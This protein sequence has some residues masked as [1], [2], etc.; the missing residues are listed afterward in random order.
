MPDPSS[1][2]SPSSLSSVLIFFV[3]EELELLLLPLDLTMG[4]KIF[5]EFSEDI[6]YSE[7][8]AELVDG[9]ALA[10]TLFGTIKKPKTSNIDM[11]H[12]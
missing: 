12:V 11:N 7:N 8:V 3:D 9:F 6:E 4:F 1:V 2:P 10:N 5:K